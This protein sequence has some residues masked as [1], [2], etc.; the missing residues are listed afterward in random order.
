M[1]LSAGK[2]LLVILIA[3]VIAYHKNILHYPR[4]SRYIQEYQGISKNIKENIWYWALSVILIA[5]AIA[6]AAV[7]FFCFCAVMSL[8]IVHAMTL[9]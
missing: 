9:K 6:F 1:I 4:I 5:I 3:I 7:V 2:A 8:F